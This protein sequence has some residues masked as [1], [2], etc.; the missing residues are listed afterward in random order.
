M[1]CRQSK[2]GESPK[3]TC[4]HIRLALKM[5]LTLEQNYA[6]LAVRTKMWTG[7][8]LALQIKHSGPIFLLILRLLLF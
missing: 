5:S 8:Y 1:N 7:R 6:W 2:Q 3:E 4:E